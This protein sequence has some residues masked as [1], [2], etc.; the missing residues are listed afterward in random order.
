MHAAVIVNVFKAVVKS[1]MKAI[2]FSFYLIG[3]Y[4]V[5]PKT[6]HHLSAFPFFTAHPFNSQFVSVGREKIAC[7][8]SESLYY[9]RSDFNLCSVSERQ[10]VYRQ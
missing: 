5:T 7:N 3:L 2:H 6:L 10:E 4:F 8:L 9:F 1:Y